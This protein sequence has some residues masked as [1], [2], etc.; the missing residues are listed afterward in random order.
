M[1]NS[2]NFNDRSPRFPGP[3]RFSQARCSARF[4]EATAAFIRSHRPA[5]VS[6]QI[7]EPP[8]QVCFRPFYTNLFGLFCPPNSHP[9]LKSELLLQFIPQCYFS[10]ANSFIFTLICLCFGNFSC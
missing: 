5:R 10:D 7:R 9:K 1:F 6:S 8:L 4:V 3:L 2:I